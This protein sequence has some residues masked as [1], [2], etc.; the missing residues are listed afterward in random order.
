MFPDTYL[1]VILL[2]KLNGC[3]ALKS[4][5]EEQEFAIPEHWAISGYESVLDEVAVETIISD[6]H[7]HGRSLAHAAVISDE[8]RR[9]DQGGQGWSTEKS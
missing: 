2:C 8:R 1:P 6:R 9:S 4:L 5:I 3:F 7:P